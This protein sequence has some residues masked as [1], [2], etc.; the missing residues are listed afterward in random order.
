MY[1]GVEDKLRREEEEKKEK[2]AKAWGPAK[3]EALWNHP[4][5]IESADMQVDDEWVDNADMMKKNVMPVERRNDPADIIEINFRQYKVDELYI[6]TIVDNLFQDDQIIKTAQDR[7]FLFDA[8]KIC[9]GNKPQVKEC[10]MRVASMLICDVIERLNRF[11]DDTEAEKKSVLVF[12][13]GL[14]EIFEFIEFIRDN[15]DT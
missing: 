15:Y 10:T 7:D 3:S 14:H 12:L 2:L 6:D 13:P 4:Q 8:K 9:E 11:G 5:P 1:V